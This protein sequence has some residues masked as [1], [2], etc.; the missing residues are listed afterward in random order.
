MI[1]IALLRG[2]NVGGKNKVDMKLLKQTFE[3]AGMKHVTTYINSGNIIFSN[4]GMSHRELSDKLEQAIVAD[5]GLNIRV[6]IRNLPEIRDTLSVLPEHWTNDA[7]M[8]SDVL[9]LWDEINDRSILGQIPIK[10][11]MDT[12]LFA[13]GAILFSVSKANA[14]KS[15]LIKL[16]GSKLYQH[17]TV[18]NVNTARKIYMLMQAAEQEEGLGRM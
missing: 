18:R 12:V 14:A 8:K 11:E 15:G 4:E 6:L 1:Y 5:F 13:S 9:F 16:V 7:D 10:P 3:Q 2:I 17:M